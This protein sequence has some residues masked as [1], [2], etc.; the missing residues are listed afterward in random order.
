MLVAERTLYAVEGMFGVYVLAGRR[1]CRG[2]FTQNAECMSVVKRT[3][4]SYECLRRYSD[5]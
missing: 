1:H 4:R 3:I 5:C 2:L